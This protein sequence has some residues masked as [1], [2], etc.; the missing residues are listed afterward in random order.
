MDSA[1]DPALAF[2]PN[3]TVYYAN[4]V[5]SRFNEGSG[6][7]VSVSHNGGLTWSEPH[8]V[9]TDGVDGSGN[10]TPTDIAND[11]EWITVDPDSGVVYVTWTQFGPTGS[12][13]VLSKSTDG[14]ATWSAPAAINPASSFTRADH[15][16]QPG[17]D[18]AGGRAPRSIDSLR[19]RV[20]NAELRPADRSRRDR[21]R[22]VDGCGNT[23]SSAEVA[24]IST[25]CST[26]MWAARH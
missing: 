2:G 19:I 23:F 26:P 14:G 21:R 13:I 22:H 11:K 1:G 3:N 16:V 17:L 5:F 12:P 20:P 7:V 4:L 8:S 24:M 15:T 18:P 9:H 6:I 10:P 25:S